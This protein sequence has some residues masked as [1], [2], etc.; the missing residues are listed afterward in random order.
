[1]FDAPSYAHIILSVET[2]T[3]ANKSILDV[4]PNQFVSIYG[5]DS[6]FCST[7]KEFSFNESVG[8]TIIL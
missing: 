4:K 8:E 6:S 2:N 5:Q 1:M 7:K 3:I